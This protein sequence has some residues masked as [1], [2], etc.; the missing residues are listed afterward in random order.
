MQEDSIDESVSPTE[1]QIQKALDQLLLE[2]SLPNL[3]KNGPAEKPV[4]TRSEAFLEKTESDIRHF[5]A[6]S[7]R[8]RVLNGFKQIIDGGR[9]NLFK[10]L[11]TWR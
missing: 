7:P 6:P 2:A 1:F 10:E 5:R 8:E 11:I 4:I 9:V 3:M